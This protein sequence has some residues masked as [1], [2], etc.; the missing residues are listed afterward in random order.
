MLCRWPSVLN[1]VEYL[2]QCCIV[3]R[4]TSNVLECHRQECICRML[5]HLGCLLLCF[6]LRDHQLA[7]VPALPDEP[8]EYV[9]VTE[10]LG[11]HE[12]HVK[13]VGRESERPSAELIGYVA[14]D[15]FAGPVDGQ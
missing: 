5:H 7:V 14:W 15:A 9:R 1:V 8:G 2:R 4:L 3:L 12:L 10:L 13:I 6:Y 11:A